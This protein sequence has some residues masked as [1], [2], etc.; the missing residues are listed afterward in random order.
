MI[1][2]KKWY[3]ILFKKYKPDPSITELNYGDISEQRPGEA[4]YGERIVFSFCCNI[5]IYKKYHNQG[6]VLK[7]TYGLDFI[8]NASE[9]VIGV[10]IKREYDK[11]IKEIEKR[12]SIKF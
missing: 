4:L 10:E 12:E 5:H 2:L 8:K 11:L 3:T 6:Y 7:K 9:Q 1:F